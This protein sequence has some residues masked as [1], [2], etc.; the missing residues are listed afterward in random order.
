MSGIQQNERSLGHIANSLEYDFTHHVT[1]ITDAKTTWDEQAKNSKINLLI[2]FYK[3][4]LK[5]HEIMS[6][7][8][9]KF[10]SLK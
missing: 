4:D 1:C 6:E 5:G 3:L 7:R 10:K 8:L 9:K 2:Q